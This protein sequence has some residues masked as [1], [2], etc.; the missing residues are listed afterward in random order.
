MASMAV[1]ATRTLI[2]SGTTRASSTAHTKL[3]QLSSPS[4]SLRVQ[5]LGNGVRNLTRGLPQV[6]RSSINVGVSS[7]ASKRSFSMAVEASTP[8]QVGEKLPEGELSYMDKDNNV[9]TVKVS[10][11]TSGKKVVLFAVPGAYTPTCSQKHVPGFV[12]K[13]GELK[14]KGVDTIACISVNDVFVLKAWGETLGVGD[15]V[16]LLSDGN[17]TFTK[18]LGVDFD[19]SDKPVGLNVR[20]RRYSML[21]DDGVVKQLNLEEGG[22]FSISGPEEIL[23]VL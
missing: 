4:A 16:L 23:K 9:Q 14:A 12:A 8:I 5:T 7:K 3:F 1:A 6:M 17:V 11:L 22:A 19:L 10:A 13:A 21:V 20:S 2:C 15:D 18:A